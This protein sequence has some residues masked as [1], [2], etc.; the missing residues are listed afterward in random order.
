MCGYVQHAVFLLQNGFGTHAYSIYFI[1]WCKVLSQQDKKI[2][3]CS[4][5]ELETELNDYVTSSD[6]EVGKEVI[7]RIKGIPYT[8]VIKDVFGK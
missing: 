3:L 6:L 4:S 1:E 7:W 8:V 2:H 5:K